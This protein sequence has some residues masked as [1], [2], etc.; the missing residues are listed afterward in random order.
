MIDL[1]FITIWL[2]I[3]TYWAYCHFS[4]RS[5]LKSYEPEMYKANSDWSPLKYTTGFAW[6][7]LALSNG[8]SM[9]ANDEVV[10]AGDRLKR[11]YELKFKLIGYGLLLSSLWFAVS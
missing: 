9:S 6:I 10:K 11:A 4:F 1:V 5:A 7:D 2:G 3:M 8:Y